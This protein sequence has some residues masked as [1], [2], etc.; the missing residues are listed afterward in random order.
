[1]KVAACRVLEFLCRAV[2]PK[3]SSAVGGPPLEIVA[4]REVRRT[5]EKQ[6]RESCIVLCDR[7]LTLYRGIGRSPPLRYGG[8]DRNGRAWVRA[9]WPR[10]SLMKWDQ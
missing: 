7:P 2:P 1:M 5:F 8:G 4:E 6:T 9:G 3:I 10:A